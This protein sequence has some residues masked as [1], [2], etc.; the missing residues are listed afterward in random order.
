MLLA[1][2]RSRPLLRASRS[3]LST[4]IVVSFASALAL[5]IAAGCSGDDDAT[6]Q[7]TAA[8][9]GAAGTS[10][11]AGHAGSAG[12]AGAGEAGAAG[13][14]GASG[15]AG[16]GLPEPEPLTCG[17]A[18][19][20]VSLASGLVENTTKYEATIAK[21]DLDAVP[22]PFDFSGE[23]PL[24]VGIIRYMLQDLEATTV[25][26]A[27]AQ[28]KGGMHL[29]VLAAAA[30]SD[31]QG[32]SGTVDIVLLRQGLHHFYPCTDQP[33]QSLALL[34]QL[35][36]DYTKW[37]TEDVACGAPKD[38]P[39]RIYAD[40]AQGVY[41]AETIEDGQIRETEVLF[42]KR[43]PDG[44]LSFAVYT[45]EGELTDR[46]T[47]ATAGGSSIVLASPF[48]CMSCHVDIDT[49][50][51]DVKRPEGTGAGCRDLVSN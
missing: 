18:L 34:K 4:R 31:D 27:D 41:V 35:V 37:D 8:G 13:D 7:T 51:Y 22:D 23:S 32:A 33:P 25:T 20:G 6:D 47:F 19:P 12:V 16:G 45:P 46:S 36:G 5:A 50:R 14:N 49:E 39:R 11:G 42:E 29:A 15:G 17:V 2:R 30:A 10:A 28:S 9:A 43:R 40:S 3:S 21:L 24:V 26:H 48:T 44:Q 1:Q 38:G